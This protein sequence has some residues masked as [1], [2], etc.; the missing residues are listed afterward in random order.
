M[1]KF[2]QKHGFTQK[3]LA[4]M[5]GISRS[6]YSCWEL[7]IRQPNFKNRLRILFFY[8]KFYLGLS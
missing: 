1:K 4:K 5:M 8:V 3:Q 7:G 6:T 2:R